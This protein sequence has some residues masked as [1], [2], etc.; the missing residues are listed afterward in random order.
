MYYSVGSSCYSNKVSKHS[1]N[2]EATDCAQVQG[3]AGLVGVMFANANL[4]TMSTN[5]IGKIIYEYVSGE[6]TY[7]PY[8]N[9]S[10]SNGCNYWITDENGVVTAWGTCSGASGCCIAG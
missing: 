9:G 1:P 8:P 2:L 4:T 3:G 5:P 7:Y 6:A 10:V